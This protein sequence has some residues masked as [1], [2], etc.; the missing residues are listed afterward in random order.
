MKIVN[1]KKTNYQNLT[2]FVIPFLFLL[3]AVW[4]FRLL[5]LSRPIVLFDN[6][7]GATTEKASASK[8]NFDLKPYPILKAEK[9]ALDFARFWIIFDNDS[10]KILASKEADSKVPIASTTKVMTAYLVLENIENLKKEIE[11]NKKAISIYQ[12]QPR[13]RWGEK[14]TIEDL[15]YILMLE[16]DNQAANVLADYIGGKVDKEA[17]TWD[18]RVAAFVKIMNEKAKKFGLVNTE[19]RDPA[20]LDS[21]TKSSSFDLAIITKKALANQTFK[22]IVSTGEKTVY[23]INQSLARPLKNSNRLVSEWSYPGIIG[24]KTGFLPEAGHCLIAAA[25]RDGHLL[26]VVVLNTYSTTPQASAEATRY[27]LDYAFKN[28]TWY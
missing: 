9:P 22:S 7:L 21:N 16:S 1:H 3:L 12:S 19:F 10:N 6:I 8:F 5:I 2:V 26:T 23:D 25:E 17:T 24:V 13:I 4:W 27:L 14:F 20:G 15:L 28:T 18:S 11:I